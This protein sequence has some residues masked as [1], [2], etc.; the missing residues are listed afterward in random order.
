MHS[1]GCGIGGWHVVHAILTI[2]TL[3]VWLPVWII[4]AVVG[5]NRGGNSVIVNR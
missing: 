3:G 5:R 4:H 1:V 2:A